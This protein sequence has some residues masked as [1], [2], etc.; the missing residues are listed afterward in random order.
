MRIWNIYKVW[1]LI[2]LIYT[3][4]YGLL[5]F[6]ALIYMVYSLHPKSIFSRALPAK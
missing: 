5:G 4:F 6:K 2:G 3:F 1:L